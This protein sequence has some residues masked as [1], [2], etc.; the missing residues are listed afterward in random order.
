MLTKIRHWVTR[1]CA[2]GHYFARDWPSTPTTAW[3]RSSWLMESEVGEAANCYKSL[4]VHCSGCV[5]CRPIPILSSQ[6]QLPPG[7]HF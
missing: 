7:L 2:C 1:A 3:A 4:A 6:M 5:T